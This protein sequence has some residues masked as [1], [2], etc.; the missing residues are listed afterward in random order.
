MDKKKV[1]VIVSGGVASIY[2]DYGVEAVCVDLDNAKVMSTNDMIPI[3]SSFVPLMEFAGISGEWPVSDDG[4]IDDA[5]HLDGK[6]L[7]QENYVSSKGQRCPNCGS[8]N[9][10]LASPMETDGSEAWGNSYCSGCLASWQDCYQLA[11]FNGL[12]Q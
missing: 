12:N 3:H 10:S 9:I 4:R 7:Q 1:L 11:G 2:A 8:D 6:G 5:D